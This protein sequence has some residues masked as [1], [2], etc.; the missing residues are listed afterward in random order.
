MKTHMF[1]STHGTVTRC[2]RYLRLLSTLDISQVD[3]GNCKASYYAEL[4]DQNDPS[5]ETP[6]VLDGRVLKAEIAE[7]LADM[8][9]SANVMTEEIKK[10]AEHEGVPPENL[11]QQDGSYI[12]L[13]VVS[14][15]ADLIRAMIDL[16]LIRE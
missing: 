16:D 6:E 3:C 15:K 13:R 12:M 8:F 10:I 9:R 14:V 1:R 2:G 4:R 11:V 7:T 5:E